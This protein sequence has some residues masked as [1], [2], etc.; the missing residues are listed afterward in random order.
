MEISE[1]VGGGLESRQAQDATFLGNVFLMSF[2]TA[3][4]IRSLELVTGESEMGRDGVLQFNTLFLV[5]HIIRDRH[6]TICIVKNKDTERLPK[7]FSPI[8][9]WL[10]LTWKPERKEEIE[11]FFKALGKDSYL[12]NL[13][14]YIRPSSPA[15][16]WPRVWSDYRREGWVL[17]GLSVPEVPG[18]IPWGLCGLHQ[19]HRVSRGQYYLYIYW[20][21]TLTAQCN[22][23][24]H[25][26]L[27]IFIFVILTTRI[28]QNTQVNYELSFNSLQPW[29]HF[30]Q[31]TLYFPYV[32]CSP[33]IK[34]SIKI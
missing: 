21:C 11:F 26:D 8:I 32:V 14:Y 13:S 25:T 5:L 17:V 34:I 20:T 24:M 28:Y 10:I 29:Q 33:M 2:F 1:E 6:K 23:H 3:L 22:M 7:S 31:K 18:Q 12:T 19:Q 27:L 4:G 16:L 30:R 9:Q 15:N